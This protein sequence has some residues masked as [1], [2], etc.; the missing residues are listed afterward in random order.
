MYAVVKNNWSQ[1]DLCV[2]QIMR[3]YRNNQEAQKSSKNHEYI[4]Y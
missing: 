1:P 4:Y 3:A 2:V